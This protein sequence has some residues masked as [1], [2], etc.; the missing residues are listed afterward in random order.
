M[1][2]TETY[3]IE[4]RPVMDAA[5]RDVPPIARIKRALKSLLRAHGLRCTNI[6]ESK[7]PD[8]AQGV[9][10]DPDDPNTE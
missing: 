10:T 7:P 2:P 4:L 9:P 8:A 1:K 5:R 3:T 6:R